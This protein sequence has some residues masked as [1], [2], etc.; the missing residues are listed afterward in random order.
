KYVDF[1]PKEDDSNLF[2]KLNVSLNMAGESMSNYPINIRIDKNEGAFLNII[3]I[4]SH[5]LVMSDNGE[6]NKKGLILD[7][8]SIRQITNTDEIDKFK[9]EPKKILDDLHACNKLAF[10]SCLKESTIQELEPS[11]K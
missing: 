10:F 6:F 2:D 7:I 11:Y 1:F 8:D 5:A 9:N 3:Q 4:L